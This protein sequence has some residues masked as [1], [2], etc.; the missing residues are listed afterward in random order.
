MSDLE[1]P[2]LFLKT[3]EYLRTLQEWTCR[4]WGPLLAGQEASDI[5]RHIGV[6]KGPVGGRRKPALTQAAMKRGNR[7][8]GG[9]VSRI[10]VC[11]TLKTRS[12]R[13]SFVKRPIPGTARSVR[14][15][16][17]PRLSRPQTRGERSLERAAP[18]FPIWP[19]T[20]WGFPCL[21]PCGWSGGL[22]PHLF[23][24]TRPVFERFGRFVF[25][26]TFRRD[27]S[28]RRLPRVSRFRPGYA[29]PRPVVFGL[30]SSPE[31]GEAILRPAK[32]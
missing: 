16:R 30:S 5:G 32:A 21:L 18:R 27:A 2:A 23:T 1:D 17:A 4:G 22:L 3:D 29:A 10:L 9:A 25:C 31:S 26:G 15:W 6:R 14:A 20:R 19:C 7:G 13:E 28:R 11:P 24:L 12:G 8:F